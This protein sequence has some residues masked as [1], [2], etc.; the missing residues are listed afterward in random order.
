MRIEKNVPA[1]ENTSAIFK[2]MDVGDSVFLDGCD[3]SSRVF[4]RAKKYFQRN[5]KKMSVRTVDGGM[6]I[7][8]VE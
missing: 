2:Q 8:R 1:P 5:G 4:H 6:R 7:W 3:Y